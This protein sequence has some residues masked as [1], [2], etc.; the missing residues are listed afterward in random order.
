MLKYHRYSLKNM[1]KPKSI[2]ETRDM[3]TLNRSQLYATLTGGHEIPFNMNGTVHPFSNNITPDNMDKV[4]EVIRKFG[5]N[6]RHKYGGSLGEID[7]A[8]KNKD[9]EY[10]RNS[11]GDLFMDFVM[12]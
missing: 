11:I 3:E 7:R 5:V 8:Y 6:G 12:D 2:T 10:F 4:M 1:E 9:L